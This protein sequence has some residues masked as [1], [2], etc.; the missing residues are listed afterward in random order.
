MKNSSE[1]VSSFQKMHGTVQVGNKDFV[2]AKGIGTVTVL[3]SVH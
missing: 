2:V 3:S 1:N